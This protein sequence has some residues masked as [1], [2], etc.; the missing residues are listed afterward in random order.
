MSVD[1]G[2]AVGGEEGE[3]VDQADGRRVLRLDAAEGELPG[4][5]DRVGIVAA[6]VALSEK[7]GPVGFEEAEVLGEG[8]AGSWMRA[9]ACSRARGRSVSA[10]ASLRAGG[11]G[12][13]P[14]GALAEEVDRGFAGKP[15]KGGGAGRPPSWDCGR[16]STRPCR[17]GMESCSDSGLAA[18]SKMRR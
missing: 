18:L 4:H 5:G 13:E 1:R 10:W 8:D 11:V 12:I 15:V 7:L 2:D 14:A 3:E 17:G 16:D 9:A 6:G